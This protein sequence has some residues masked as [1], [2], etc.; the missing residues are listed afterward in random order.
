M[1]YGHFQNFL[2]LFLCENFRS[3]K[4]PLLT[5]QI[6]YNLIYYFYFQ[7]KSASFN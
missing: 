4:K 6:T 2:L 1:L 3:P 7:H 5:K